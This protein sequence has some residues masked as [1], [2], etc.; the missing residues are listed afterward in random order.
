MQTQFFPSVDLTCAVYDF[1][2]LRN[3][4]DPRRR[5]VSYLLTLMLRSSSQVDS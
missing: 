3:C 1:V 2:D 4:V 5:V